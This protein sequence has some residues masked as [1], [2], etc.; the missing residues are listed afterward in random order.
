MIL[1]S[2]HL[3]VQVRDIEEAKQ[4]YSNLLGLEQGISDTNWI[5]YNM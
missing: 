1:T 2:F 3:A 5:D 4:F